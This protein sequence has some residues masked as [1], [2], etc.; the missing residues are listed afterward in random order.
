MNPDHKAERSRFTRTLRQV[1]RKYSPRHFQS[2]WLEFSRQW[3]PS[4]D[5]RIS[6][7]RTLDALLRLLELDLETI[8]LALTEKSGDTGGAP[9]GQ[10]PNK[11][12]RRSRKPRRRLSLGP[13][14]WRTA[15]GPI[16]VEIQDFQHGRCLVRTTSGKQELVHPKALIQ[17]Q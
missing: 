6:V 2:A 8:E 5:P 14:V 13:A 4:H 10:Y 16:P 9:K 3:H 12:R 7:A 15:R 11:R 17:E 1:M